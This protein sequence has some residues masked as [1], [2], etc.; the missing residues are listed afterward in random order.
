VRLCEWGSDEAMA[1][2]RDTALLVYA[3]GY[4]STAPDLVDDGDCPI[5]MLRHGGFVA[6]DASCRVLGHAGPI[7]GVYGVGIGFARPDSRG[8]RRVSLNFFHGLDA[9]E[10]LRDLI[11]PVT[12][13][14]KGS[15]DVQS[16]W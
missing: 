7:R 16:S 4:R 9:E 8:E 12:T 14:P 3:A 2:V 15:S 10:I 1:A 11:Q 5:P 6:V 13:F